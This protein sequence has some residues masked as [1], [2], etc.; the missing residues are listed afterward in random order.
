MVFDKK[1]GDEKTKAKRALLGLK[2][3]GRKPALLI[4]TC[5]APKL[6]WDEILDGCKEIGVLPLLVDKKTTKEARE[7]MLMAADI[8]LVFDEE[9]LREA[10]RSACVPVAP[11]MGETTRN[12]NPVEED[13]NGFFFEKHT[14]WSVFAAVVRA[15]ETYR[16]PYD[17]DNVVKEA[18]L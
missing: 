14:Q 4:D 15:L 5:S 8:A 6:S 3:I 18:S 16:F 9:S 10:R 7:K 13:G 2:A 11:F 17:W 1:I 12:Y